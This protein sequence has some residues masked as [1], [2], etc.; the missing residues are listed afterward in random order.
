[1]ASGPG[2]NKI[3]PDE[4]LRERAFSWLNGPGKSFQ[5]ASSNCNY[6][7]SGRKPFPLNPY[8]VSE[9]VLSE[10]LREEVYQ[11]VAVKGESV[12]SVSVKFSITMERV[13]AVVRLKQME[14]NWESEVRFDLLFLFPC[15][16]M[17]NFKNSI[18]L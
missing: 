16:R 7:G 18:S 4:I 3:E 11:S 5:S 8:F 15:I 9:S 1:M 17:M 2:N 12:R 6:L 10:R 13:A 14:K